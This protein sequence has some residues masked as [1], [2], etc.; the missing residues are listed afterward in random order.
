MSETPANNPEPS[1]Q[2]PE[3]QHQYNE[4]PP[5]YPGLQPEPGA[6]AATAPY[7]TYPQGYPQPMDPKQYPPMNL[8]TAP[9]P[10]QE[11]SVT[12]VHHYPTDTQPQPTGTQQ[13]VVVQAGNCPECRIG[14]IIEDFTC[15]GI[16]MG[17]FFFPC[18]L[19]CCLALRQRRCSH[20]GAFF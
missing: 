2:V 7:P 14:T 9:A 5:P 18:G 19:L 16:F 13:V 6:A 4:P 12:V 11:H 3:E 15:M 10:G 1:K 20:C 8:G 17:I